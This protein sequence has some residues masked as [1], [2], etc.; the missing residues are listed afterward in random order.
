LVL[1]KPQKTTR[2]V[3]AERS[4]AQSDGKKQRFSDPLS[5]KTLSLNNK[6]AMS[7]KNERLSDSIFVSTKN[8]KFHDFSSKGS[9]G[10]L[11]ETFGTRNAASTKAVLS[12]KQLEEIEKKLTMKMEA[13]IDEKLEKRIKEI[14]VKQEF[15]RFVNKFGI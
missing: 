5:D 2:V 9:H 6:G 1:A 3:P 11:A 14:S 12:E 4:N 8:V 10:C 13:N 7:T 15:L